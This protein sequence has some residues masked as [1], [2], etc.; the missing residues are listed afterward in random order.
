MKEGGSPGWGSGS[1]L[2]GWMVI[3]STEKWQ[4]RFVEKIMGSGLGHIDLEK[5]HP[6]GVTIN[7]FEMQI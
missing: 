7:H 5:P 6:S 4:L 2:D 3:L 1:G